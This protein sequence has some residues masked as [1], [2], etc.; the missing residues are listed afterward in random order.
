M[1]WIRWDWMEDR[2]IRI[3]ECMG[4]NDKGEPRH[5]KGWKE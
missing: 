2:M 3:E 5:G 1:D 4:S